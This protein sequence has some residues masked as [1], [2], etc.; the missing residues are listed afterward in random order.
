MPTGDASKTETQS[1]S[2]SPAPRT[3]APWSVCP[4]LMYRL[5]YRVT[6][7]HLS[8]SHFT[9]SFAVVSAT[10]RTRASAIPARAVTHIRSA[11]L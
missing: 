5:S 1:L 11:T 9:G 6:Y 10:P 4:L 3:G 8:F 7:L 2:F